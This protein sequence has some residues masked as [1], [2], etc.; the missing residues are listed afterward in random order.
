MALL[1]WLLATAFVAVVV[2]LSTVRY[3][4]KERAEILRE[5]KVAF[6]CTYSAMSVIAISWLTEGLLK[7]LVYAVIFSAPAGLIGTQMGFEFTYKQAF[8]NGFKVT[9]TLTTITMFILEGI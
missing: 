6:Y 9:L 8:K 4:G 1:I 2:S 3:E 7:A 5:T